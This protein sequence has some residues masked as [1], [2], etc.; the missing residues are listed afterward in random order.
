M[1]EE[2]GGAYAVSGL[3]GAL[4]MCKYQDVPLALCSECR[5]I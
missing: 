4:R 2:S 1:Q 5:E 3:R